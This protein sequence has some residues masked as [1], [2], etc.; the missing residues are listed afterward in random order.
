MCHNGKR[1]FL[2]LLVFLAAMMTAC[3][4]VGTHVYS[5]G[6][7]VSSEQGFGGTIT[8]RMT[9]TADRIVDVKVDGPHE[10]EGVGSVAVQKLPASI[11]ASQ[12][13]DIDGISGATYSSRAIILAA[14][15]CIGKAAG[16]SKPSAVSMKAGTYKGEALG[17][18]KSEPVRVAV[19]VSEK[20]I[21]NVEVDMV[22]NS[23]T[24]PI[25]ESA[26]ALLVPRI[27]KNQSV[28]VDSI[29]G[30]T[31]S[32]AAIKSAVEK[33]LVAALAAGGSDESAIRNFYKSP[34]KG[35]AKET[36][37]TDV[38]V[39][40]MGGSGMMS[41]MRAAETGASV[42]A[43][44]KTG[45]IGGTSALTSEI[46][47]I[48][49]P[50]IQ[51]EYNNGKDW[52]DV[53]AMRK[54]W[55]DYTGDDAKKELVEYLMTESGKAIDWLVF[56]HQF[57]FDYVP[58]NGFTS[59]DV[60]LVKYQYMP[61]NVRYDYSTKAA[62]FKHLAEDFVKAGGKYMLETEG[63][64]L[65]LDASGKVVGANARNLVD[66]TEYTINAKT[67]IL[68]T[69]GFAGNG[70]MEEKYLS[71]KYFPLKG[72]WCQYGLHT[73]DGKM[74]QAALDVG[75]GTYNIGVAPMVHNAGTP[76]FLTGFET[77]AVKGKLGMRTGR[78][79][80]WS[81]GDI[82]LF[83]ASYVGAMTVDK[84]GKRF[85][86]EDELAHLN[87]WIGG[88]RFYTIWS[89][90]QIDDLK[91]NGFAFAPGGRFYQYL[92]Y[93]AEIPLNTPM[94]PVY[95]VLD[96]AVKAGIAYKADTVEELAKMIGCSPAALS[97]TVSDYNGYCASGVDQDFGKSAKHLIS[98]KKAPYYAIV[99]APWCYSTCG[100]LDVNTDFQVLKADGRTP[101]GGLYCVGT[102]CMGVL[103]TERKAYVTFGGAA[104]GW[105]MTSAY[106][107]GKK[108]GE[109]SK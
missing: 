106:L 50:K 86:D 58:K 47:A 44:E 104:N 90:D 18:V 99:G 8:V 64:K 107:A 57:K 88:S 95:E 33:C 39:I 65:I 45:R 91:N 32:S 84:T 53:D 48:N 109:A 28:K 79:M 87:S 26:V 31:S 6:T 11:L 82:P 41:A 9:F 42:L 37:N 20:K 30:A 22:N 101:I 108:A 17:F 81:Y 105:A 69:G 51:A 94:T 74:I 19:T 38:L 36:L 92:G 34:A 16:G 60:F 46:F 78:P 75:A 63:Y 66:G 13:A 21:E 85:S 55:L 24:K 4:S 77:V 59:D 5:P 100:G 72:K 80:V 2:L 49:P 68:A 76:S 83:M 14:S 7:Y 40:G 61:N 89:G 73:N 97:K 25:L 102:D 35:S 70:A 98:L 15:D 10:T 43:I 93:G 52:V 1:V 27:L 23:E 56:D 67:V 54:A 103:F 3:S 62:Y 29:T 96:A 12:S 71:D